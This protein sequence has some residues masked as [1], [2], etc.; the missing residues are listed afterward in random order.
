[1]AGVRARRDKNGNLRY[2]E[3]WYFDWQGKRQYFKGT[4]SERQTRVLAAKEEEHHRMIKLGHLPP[5]KKSDDPHDFREIVDEYLAWG[6]SQ[7][8]RGGRPWAE[9]HAR[10]RRTHLA[11]WEEQLGLKL[12]SDLDGSL[13]RVE[14]AL[15]ARQ[16]E[17]LTGGTRQNYREAIVGL[18]NW[19][20]KRGYLERNPLDGL[21]PFDKTPQVRRALLTPDEIHKLLA[22]C[23]ERRLLLYE[24][25]FCSGLR[26]KELRSLAVPDLDTVR[27]GLVLHDKWAKD[28]KEGFQPLPASLVTRLAAY[29]ESGEA[30]QLY[31][32]RYARRDASLKGIPDDPLLYVPKMMAREMTKDLKAAELPTFKPGEGKIDFHAC[33]VA[34]VTYVLESGASMKEAQDLARHASPEMTRQVYA[35]TRPERIKRSVEAVGSV[36]R[37]E[38]NCGHGVAQKAAGAEG[39]DVNA[40]D[41]KAKEVGCPTEPPVSNPA[42]S[43]PV[44]APEAKDFT[45][46]TPHE[47]DE[48][49]ACGVFVCT[50]AIDVLGATWRCCVGG[51]TA[52]LLPRRKGLPDRSSGPGQCSEH[53]EAKCFPR[54]TSALRP[55]LPHR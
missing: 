42:V 37:T 33:R 18:C 46:E 17:G 9:T 15:Q 31:A 10:M 27:N 25:A 55:E 1:M 51:V 24:T 26:A 39:V 23:P 36:I 20:V 52:G 16:Q 8:G 14:K 38:R 5:P 32:R 12:L 54:A 43:T 28:R 35:R 22:T 47:P 11:W 53:A 45:T 41:A 29:A 49:R 40:A 2:W 48:T 21:A 13:P 7:G 3:G 30:K 6:D 4:G 19:C 50:G 44:S 34:Y